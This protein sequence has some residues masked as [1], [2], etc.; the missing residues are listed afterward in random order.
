M[1][2]APA[3]R[4][5]HQRRERRHLSPVTRNLFFGVRR[6]ELPPCCPHSDAT[7]R[8]VSATRN[9]TFDGTLVLDLL[10][11]QFFE[12]PQEQQQL[13]LIQMPMNSFR[14]PQRITA[15]KRNGGRH[16][17]QPPLRRAKDLPVFVTW[18]KPE[19]PDPLSILAHQ[20]RRRFRSDRSL[21]RGAR[22]AYPTTWPEGS[23]VFRP[24][25]PALDRS[26]RRKPSDVQRPFLGNPLS[27]PASLTSPTRSSGAAS[28]DRKISLPAPLPGWPRQEPESSSHRLP[29]EIGPLVTCRALVPL[30]ALGEAGTAVPIT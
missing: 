7:I 25:R 11:E 21:F 1:C 13:N 2:P 15:H 16:C 22:P 26:P 29:A 10:A 6:M 8:Y 30:P 20:L 17:C 23:L 3:A 14:T 4:C 18:S 19:G 9:R 5:H 27:R 12:T 24:V 28:R